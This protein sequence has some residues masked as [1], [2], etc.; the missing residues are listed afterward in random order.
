[1]VSYLLIAYRN[2]TFFLFFFRVS[3]KF[4]LVLLTAIGDLKMFFIFLAMLFVSFTCPFVMLSRGNGNKYF[5]G[6]EWEVGQV[7]EPL[8][9]A[10]FY[11]PYVNM[12]EAAIGEYGFTEDFD[13]DPSALNR[14]TAW[15]IFIIMT[16]IVQVIM[17]N[18]IIG[19][20]GKSY[21]NV[22]D[23]AEPWI[24]KVRADMSNKLKYLLDREDKKEVD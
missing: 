7:E 19:I 1:V 5:D 14:M 11:T 9:F 13:S 22:Y 20:V 8:A 4:V 2:F 15:G 17:M 18:L 21:E 10:T 16:F 3:T 6:Q 12:Y 23:N 24:Y